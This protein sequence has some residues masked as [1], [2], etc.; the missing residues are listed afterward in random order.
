LSF[1]RHFRSERERNPRERDRE[2]ERL[3]EVRQRGGF[4]MVLMVVER[5]ILDFF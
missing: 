5:R 4:Y 2:K 1:V 3:S